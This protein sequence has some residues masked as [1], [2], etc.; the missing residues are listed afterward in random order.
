LI[1]VVETIFSVHTILRA[2]RVQRRLLDSIPDMVMV[3]DS[4]FNVV[5]INRSM[6]L[7]HCSA[8]GEVNRRAFRAVLGMKCHY[9]MFNR[10]QS[11]SLYGDRCP[12]RHLESGGEMDESVIHCA[13]R[14]FHLT[15]TPLMETGQKRTFFVEVIRDITAQEIARQNL[16]LRYGFEQAISRAGAELIQDAPVDSEIRGLISAVSHVVELIRAERWYFLEWNDPA[17]DW[18]SIARHPDPDRDTGG[19]NTEGSGGIRSWRLFRDRVV[20][21][22]EIL[23]IPDMSRLDETDRLPDWPA[24]AVRAVV[25]V[26][27]SRGRRVIRVLGFERGEPGF[28]WP[29]DILPMMNVFAEIL[30][31][32]VERNRN[33][34]KL[35]QQEA[36]YRRLAENIPDL[37]WRIRSDGILEYANPALE[38]ILGYRRE[39][40]VG[41]PVNRM[42]QESVLERIRNMLKRSGSAAIGRRPVRFSDELRHAKGHSVPCE[43]GIT[44]E[45]DPVQ[46]T[47]AYEG[48]IRDLSEIKRSEAERAELQHRFYQ[49]QRM[50]TIG[51]MASG[52]AHEINNPVGIIIGFAEYLMDSSQVPSDTLENIRLIHQEAV[53]IKELT[54][55]LMDFARTGKHEISLLDINEPVSDCLKLIRH[56]LS[57]RRI[58]VRTR[59]TPDLPGILGN[60]NALK[61]VV[62]NLLINAMEAIPRHSEGVIDVSTAL[63]DAGSVVVTLSDNGIG[64]AEEAREKI[65]DPFYSGKEQGS[66][67][68]LSISLNIMEQ[69]NGRMTC[70]SRLGHGTTFILELPVPVTQNSNERGVIH[71]G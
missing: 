30:S 42:I 63:N 33:A 68:G 62:M 7:H 13:D 61:Q 14:S 16:E 1:Q 8:V 20:G 57:K 47:T 9:L 22:A 18:I 34:L 11:C 2:S 36:R 56:T 31:S 41:Q 66:G 52:L 50:E 26:P 67:L 3:I 38:S 54:Q 40:V 27:I 70:T 45:R 28:E 12:I 65:F 58:V 39:D 48:I 29:E 5:R 19:E 46:G 43:I 59:L 55:R 32:A 10:D 15:T 4:Q 64:I 49:A 21:N 17:G 53:R 25:L 37:I 51:S 24:R 44:V 69:H 71:E 60:R 23:H 6:L 35:R